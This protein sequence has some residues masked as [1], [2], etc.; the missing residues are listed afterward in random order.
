MAPCGHQVLFLSYFTGTLDMQYVGIFPST[1]YSVRMR[2]LKAAS[3]DSS[4]AIVKHALIDEEK[5]KRIETEKRLKQL[6]LAHGSVF[7]ALECAVKVLQQAKDLS[8][9]DHIWSECCK[10]ISQCY[11]I[12]G[13]PY[14]KTLTQYSLLRKKV[15]KSDILPRT[16]MQFGSLEVTG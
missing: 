9:I 4:I 13:R 3:S 5:R 11:L 12:S 2:H 16:S 6:I 10:A 8:V 7:R 15:K 1:D 14:I